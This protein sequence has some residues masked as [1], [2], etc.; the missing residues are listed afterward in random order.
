MNHA[1]HR[2]IPSAA[3]AL[4][5]ALAVAGCR[6]SDS[7][8]DLA[9]TLTFDDVAGLKAGDNVRMRGV[10]IGTVHDI[11]LRRDAVEVA[12]VIEGRHAEAVTGDATFRIET[13]RLIASK[14][15][16][17]VEPG[18]G[19]AAPLVS[20]AE[21]RGEG[22]ATLEQK[23]EAVIDHA[24]ERIGET[25]RALVDEA[26]GELRDS[27][28]AVVRSAEAALDNLVDPG[29][30]VAADAPP[31]LRHGR[32]PELVFEP[33][34]A[35]IAHRKANRKKWDIV[36]SVPEVLLTVSCDET[37]VLQLPEK[38]SPRETSAPAWKATSL[39]FPYREGGF[40]IVRMMDED[41]FRNDLIAEGRLPF[42]EPAEIGDVEAVSFGQVV[43]FRYRFRWAE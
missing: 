23:A 10:T 36:D 12:I 38:E 29:S 21:L 3:L 18:V 42:P 8:A 33:L 17:L 26:G 32:S 2:L 13:E 20:G 9:L 43:E 11:Q 19:E 5:V 25:G 39:P 35:R 4:L 41:H 16:V 27:G 30:R 6:A 28:H 37:I 40:L 15:C 22:V 31:V 24:A 7:P 14:R 1:I 34:T